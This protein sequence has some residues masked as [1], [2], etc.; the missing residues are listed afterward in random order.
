MKQSLCIN[1][2]VSEMSPIKH[3]EYLNIV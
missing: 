1:S 2:D 3:E